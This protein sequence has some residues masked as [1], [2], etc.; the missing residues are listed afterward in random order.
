MIHTVI[1]NTS[2]F[3][4]AVKD[5]TFYISKERYAVEAMSHVLLTCL[6]AE[7]RLAVTGCDGHGYYERRLA[8]FHGE[9]DPKPSLPGEKQQLCISEKDAAML[10]KFI[11]GRTLGCITL[12]LDDGQKDEGRYLVTVTMP[13][14]SA[15]SFFSRADLEVPEYSGFVRKAEASKEQAP[16]L[17][18]VNMPVHEMIR[19]GKVFPKKS[20]STVRM[21]T[22]PGYRGGHMALLEYRDACADVDIRVIFMFALAEAEAA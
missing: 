18:N 6:P 7:N 9:N 12:R 15:T 21:F 11:G 5:A 2:Q 14:D 1:I 4:Q 22:S 19:A 16:E 13:D 20:G 10:V 17:C 3:S 8:L